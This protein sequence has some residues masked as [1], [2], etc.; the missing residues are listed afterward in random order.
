MQPKI[1]INLLI[2]AQRT[3][4]KQFHNVYITLLHQHA[5]FYLSNDQQTDELRKALATDRYQ[6]PVLNTD[7]ATTTTT[8]LRDGHVLEL[9]SEIIENDHIREMF[10]QLSEKKLLDDKSLVDLVAIY[11]KNIN[12]DQIVDTDC[13][14]Y[15]CALLMQAIYETQSIQFENGSIYDLHDATENLTVDTVYDRL[16]VL[17]HQQP[18][19]AINQFSAPKD[20]DTDDIYMAEVIS[21]DQRSIDQTVAELSAYIYGTDI[22]RDLGSERG[23]MHYDH[24][25]G[26]L[27]SRGHSFALSDVTATAAHID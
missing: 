4:A 8:Y 25:T 13:I 21:P 20:I 18:Y 15:Y 27:E 22:Q 1:G 24:V 7:I 12:T 17:M 23:I 26:E 9:N 14:S 11:A 3:Y 16:K 19:I 6:L 5:N 2:K 10:A